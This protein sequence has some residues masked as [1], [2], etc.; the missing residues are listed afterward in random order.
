MMEQAGI[1]VSRCR[2]NVLAP[3]SISLLLLINMKKI[4]LILFVVLG[5]TSLHAQ[6]QNAYADTKTLVPMLNADG[7]FSLDEPSWFSII[8]LYLPASAQGSPQDAYEELKKNFILSALFEKSLSVSNP[9]SPIYSQAAVSAGGFEFLAAGTAPSTSLST[10]SIADAL[11][12][13]I[14][15]RAKEELTTTFFEQMKKI[16]QQNPE[17]SAAFPQTTKAI[18]QIEPYLYA[19]YINTLRQSFFA[20]LNNLPFD[21][22]AILRTPRIKAFMKSHPKTQDV[23][24]AVPLMQCLA[25]LRAGE[26]IADAIKQLYPDDE[27]RT[28]DPVCYNTLKIIVALSE[29]I[30]DKTNARNWIT[31]ADLVTLFNNKINSTIFLGLIYEETK[32]T[33]GNEYIT[34]ANAPAI[35]AL[36]TQMIQ[37]YDDVTNSRSALLQDYNKVKQATKTGTKPKLD[38]VINLVTDVNSGLKT[39]FDAVNALTHSANG[40]NPDIYFT[41][42]P[43]LM[44]IIRNF[45]VGSYTTGVAN[46]I[47]LINQFIANRNEIALPFAGNNAFIAIQAGTDASDINQQITSALSAF[48]TYQQ[49]SSQNASANVAEKASKKITASDKSDTNQAVVLLTALNNAYASFLKDPTQLSALNKALNNIAQYQPKTNPKGFYA[50]DVMQQLL[51]YATLMASLAEAKTSADAQTALEAAIL[52]VGSSAIKYYTAYSFSLNSYIGAAWFNSSY[53][54]LNQA[55]KESFS[56]LGVALPIGPN[57]SVSTRGNVVGAVSLFVSVIDIGAVASYRLNTPSN[58]TTGTLPA[59]TLQNIIA[60]GA[61]LVL[62]RIAKTPLALGVGWQRAPQL[63]AIQNGTADIASNPKGRVGAF[64]SVDIP[65]FNLYSH[66]LKRPILD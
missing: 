50:S 41:D 35:Q 25:S 66:A 52:P 32:D 57:F 47:T 18:Q 9:G 33:F 40:F 62:N 12:Q 16:L 42:F 36:L 63:S 11:T 10:A 30:R 60:P 48:K 22:G 56:T 39:T 64:I 61:F 7:K 46:A 19:S 14:I 37:D 51:K 59:F 1:S 43:Q 21:I 55:G 34:A 49:Q 15:E 53:Q 54:M 20:D 23:W 4:I 38:D 24:Y 45:D 31:A 58:A 17:L 13:L 65:L 44:G 26:P 29:S 28:V 2:K 6:M 27:L 5:W 3:H 8:K